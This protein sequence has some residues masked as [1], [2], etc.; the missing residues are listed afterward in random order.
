LI[1]TGTDESVQLLVPHSLRPTPRSNYD[2]D[3]IW[4]WIEELLN[5]PLFE[6][7][8]LMDEA[9]VTEASD[10]GSRKRKRED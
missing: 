4:W 1:V 10:D 3:N 6:E 5:M 9:P 2:G 8:A 7:E